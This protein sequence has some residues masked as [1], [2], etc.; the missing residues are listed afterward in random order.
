MKGIL[1]KLLTFLIVMFGWILFRCETASDAF[2]YL[3]AMFAVNNLADF[4]FYKYSYYVNNEV[5]FVTIIGVILSIISFEKIKIRYAESNLKGAV[6]IVL[7]M[8][9]MVYMSDASFHAFIYFQF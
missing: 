1:G 5:I 9:C 7:L 6:C 2:E 4:Q 8:F 3:K